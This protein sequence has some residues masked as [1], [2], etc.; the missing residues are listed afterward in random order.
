MPSE[1]YMA[2]A[3]LVLSTAAQDVPNAHLVRTL[4]KVTTYSNYKVDVCYKG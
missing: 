4:V 2:V 3:Q 1:H